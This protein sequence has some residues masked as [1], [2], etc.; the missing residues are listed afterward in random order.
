VRVPRATVRRHPAVS[1][2]LVGSNA[3][4]RAYARR[5]ARAVRT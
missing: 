1:V 5:L 3:G 2:A 4:L